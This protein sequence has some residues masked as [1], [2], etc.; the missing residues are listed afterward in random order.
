[1]LIKM[2]CLLVYHPKS[3]ILLYVSHYFLFYRFSN[4]K[5]YIMVLINLWFKC[6]ILFFFNMKVG[7]LARN[8]TV[9]T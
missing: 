2:N 9:V 8:Q 1:M 7:F 4:L 3:V 6:L 5:N